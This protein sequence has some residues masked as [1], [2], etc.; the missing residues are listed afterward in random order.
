MPP[1]DAELVQRF[2]ERRDESAFRALVERHAAPAL[3]TAHRITGDLAAAEDAVQE[4]FFAVMRGL[5][6]FNPRRS[7]RA[8]TLG[9]AAHCS[10]KLVRSRARRKKDSCFVVD[11]L[12]ECIGFGTGQ[13]VEEDH[14]QR[15]TGE[16][17]RALTGIEQEQIMASGQNHPPPR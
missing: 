4:T 1:T 7:F 13:A 6:R 2:L 10:M 5:A 3:R 14:G 9:I 12:H 17:F 15:Y 8:W 16:E 11:T